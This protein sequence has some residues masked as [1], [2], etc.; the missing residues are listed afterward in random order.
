M[1][2]SILERGIGGSE[3]PQMVHSR[4]DKLFTGPWE[5]SPPLRA[6]IPHCGFMNQYGYISTT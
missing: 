6:R 3:L 1:I 2:T 5:A 4:L